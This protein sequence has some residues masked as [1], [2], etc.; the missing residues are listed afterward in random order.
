MSALA[1]LLARI[2]FRKRAKPANK[3]PAQKD[4]LQ[5]IP[6]DP[7]AVIVEGSNRKKWRTAKVQ[8]VRAKQGGGFQYMV[9]G[10][11]YDAEQLERVAT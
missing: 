3:Q 7:V 8:H 9:N 10:R 1:A 5:F 11:Y 4:G 2:L 6:G